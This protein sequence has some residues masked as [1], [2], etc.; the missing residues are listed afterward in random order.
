[1]TLLRM[2][3][4]GRLVHLVFIVEARS[5]ST[6]SVA[7]SLNSPAKIWFIITKVAEPQVYDTFGFEV[8]KAWDSQWNSIDH[9]P[10]FLID[11]WALHAAR[12]DVFSVYHD[13]PQ[14]AMTD[15][16]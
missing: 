14:L 16:K 11:Q 2:H 4:Q 6:C 5:V 7:T 15:P 3:R 12:A 1:M 13:G 9:Q 8:Q 10:T